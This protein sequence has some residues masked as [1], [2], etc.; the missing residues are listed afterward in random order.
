MQL[1]GSLTILSGAIMDY[2]LDT[3]LDSSE[4]Y[5]PTGLLVLNRQN[6]SDFRFAPSGGFAP[7]SYML[8]DA[9]SVNGTLGA[10][11]SGTING[12]QASLAMQGNDLVL[13]V[14]PE[15]GAL[16]L[17]AAGA[18]RSLASGL[19]S[20]ALQT[21]ALNRAIDRLVGRCGIAH[22]TG[23]GNVRFFDQPRQPLALDKHFRRGHDKGIVRKGAR[24]LMC[25]PPSQV[26]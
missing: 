1:S 2:D 10:N 5:M 18:S 22:W 20:K 7:G 15:P 8:I 3:P 21:L 4:V 6:F 14:V 11:T 9:G 25:R 19:A 16:S 23:G 12:R 24:P 26:T 17:L 13:T